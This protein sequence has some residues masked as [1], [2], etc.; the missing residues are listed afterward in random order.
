[1]S[2]RLTFPASVKRA[3]FLFAAKD[4]SIERLQ[5]ERRALEIEV[6][7]LTMDVQK[8]VLDWQQ[9]SKMEAELQGVADKL[10]ETELKYLLTKE[11]KGKVEKDLKNTTERLIM[12]QKGLSDAQ[13]T[14]KV[15]EAKIKQLSADNFDLRA[16]VKDKDESSYREEKLRM[17]NMKSLDA[18]KIKLEKMGVDDKRQRERLFSLKSACSE[19]NEAYE[20]V[21]KQNHE[22]KRDMEDVKKRLSE[23]DSVL[24]ITEKEKEQMEEQILNASR[25]IDDLRK[26]SRRDESVSPDSALGIS[27]TSAFEF[28]SGPNSPN[29][30]ASDNAFSGD[31]FGQETGLLC[32]MPT[33]IE[34]FR[35]VVRDN[36]VLRGKLFEVAVHKEKQE[37]QLKHLTQLNEILKNDVS[38]KEKSVLGLEDKVKFLEGDTRDAKN[39]VVELERNFAVVSAQADL[40]KTSLENR[41]E[42]FVDLQERIEIQEEKEK[43][44]ELYSKSVA[45]KFEYESG[46]KKKYEGLYR[47]LL[48]ESTLQKNK[49]QNIEK[50]LSAS[51]SD[52]DSIYFSAQ[53]GVPMATV[54]DKVDIVLKNKKDLEVLVSNLQ[55]ECADLQ[56][57]NGDL[58]KDL[59]HYLESEKLRQELEGELKATRIRDEQASAKVVKLDEQKK[60]LQNENKSLDAAISECKKKEEKLEIKAGAMKQTISELEKAN[61][62]F[63]AQNENL[64]DDLRRADDESSK[65]ASELKSFQAKMAE[66]EITNDAFHAE[67]EKLRTDIMALSEAKCDVELTISETERQI[68]KLKEST[69]KERMNREIL[70]VQKNEAL[71]H[72]EELQSELNGA[73]N[74]I[75]TMEEK[76][77]EAEKSIEVMEKSKFDSSS[78]NRRLAD[79]LQ[80]VKKD[81]SE[82]EGRYNNSIQE[83]ENLQQKLN[84]ASLEMAKLTTAHEGSVKRNDAME[85]NLIESK[86]K[87]EELEILLEKTRLEK[88]NV[89]RDVSQ[90]DEVIQQLEAK[91]HELEEERQSLTNDLYIATRKVLA[92][93]QNAETLM[94]E[95]NHMNREM[96]GTIKNTLNKEG[97]SNE[98]E[99]TS[100]GDSD[101]VVSEN[102]VLMQNLRQSI[103][104]TERNLDFFRSEAK[105]PEHETKSCQRDVEFIN[106]EFSLLRNQLSSFSATSH[107]LCEDI[108]KLKEDLAQKES[109]LE[110]TKEQHNNLKEENLENRESIIQLQNKCTELEALFGEYENKAEKQHADLVRTNQQIST[111]DSNLLRSEQKKTALEKELLV[112]HEKISYLEANARAM[113]DEGRSD[114]KKIATLETEYNE[115]QTLARELDN[116]EATLREL[117]GKLDDVLKEKEEAKTELY[118]MREELRQQQVELKNARK[119][120]DH[121]KKQ[122]NSEKDT[123]QKVELDLNENTAVCKTYKSN[124]QDLERSLARLREE[125]S[126]L[127]EKVGILDTTGNALRKETELQAIEMRRLEEELAD[128]KEQYSNLCRNHEGSE[129]DRKKLVNEM[130]AADER[131]TKLQGTCDELLKEK[132][133]SSSKVLSLNEALEVIIS[134]NEETAGNLKTDLLTAKKELSITK[135]ALD[136]RQKQVEELQDELKNDELKIKSLEEKKQEVFEKYWTS[137]NELTEAEGTIDNLRAENKELKQQNASSAQRAQNLQETL[138]SERETNEK[139]VSAWSD[140]MNKLKTLHQKV[141]EERGNFK[142]D[143]SYTQ[144]SLTKTEDDLKQTS[145][146]LSEKERVFNDDVTKRDQVLEDFSAQNTNLKNELAKTKESLTKTCAENEDLTERLNFTSE[147]VEWLEKELQEKNADIE[148]L[149]AEAQAKLNVVRKMKATNSGEHFAELPSSEFMAREEQDGIDGVDARPVTPLNT[150]MKDVVNS[151]HKS[152][153]SSFNDNRGL[154]QVLTDKLEEIARLE[155]GL[156]KEKNNTS[157]MKRYLHDLEKKKGKL[158]DEVKRLRRRLEALKLKS[159]EMEKEKDNEITETKGDKI[160]LE[161]ELWDTKEALEES[162]AKLKTTEEEKDRYAKDLESSRKQIVDAK[163]DIKGSQ[164]QLDALQE[165]ILQLKKRTFELEAN[166]RASQQLI[167]DKDKELFANQSKID[168]LE[169][170]YDNA[171]DKKTELFAKLSRADER[172]ASLENDCQDNTVKEATLESQIASLEVKVDDRSTRL[173]KTEEELNDSREKCE[174]L[175]IQRGSLQATNEILKQQLDATKK[176]CAQFQALLQKEKELSNTFSGQLNEVKSNKENLDRELKGTLEQKEH[177]QQL[178]NKSEE[179]LNTA[180]ENNVS[181]FH[182]IENLKRQMVKVQSGACADSARKQLEIGKLKAEGETL[183]KELKDKEREHNENTTKFKVTEKENEF[184]KKDLAHKHSRESEL[185]LDLTSTNSK[186]HSYVIEREC[187]EREVKSVLSEMEQQKNASQSKEER[188]ERLRT[189]YENEIKFLQDRVEALER[190][191]RIIQEANEQ[192]RHADEIAS[193]LAIESKDMEIDNLKLRLQATRMHTSEKSDVL[194]IMKEQLDERT[195]QIADLM[196]QLRMLKESY[197]LEL[198]SLH[199][200]LKCAQMENMLHK[201]EEL[202]G[203][204]GARQE[205]ELLEAI[206]Q[207]RKESE[208]LR[209]LLKGKMKDMKSLRKH[210]LTDR[211]SGMS[212]K[213]GYTT[214]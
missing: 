157:E 105:V 177:I 84:L 103:R 140:Q 14:I 83:E 175:E 64:K 55:A 36:E 212:R 195:R 213:P 127:E 101:T 143:L 95:I 180:E 123:R 147:K 38:G 125:N 196:E 48:E 3:R 204:F 32:K 154:Q 166:E 214:Y 65:L 20:I 18:L 99:K 129:K 155:E 52:R 207:S 66:I 194:D 50:K 12:L 13:G 24:E 75:S 152:C 120:V 170:L 40:L 107:K 115:K 68:K 208:R 174:E 156:Q 27:L 128:T 181:S 171:N 104:A 138:Q 118:G 80:L 6:A 111:L 10:K 34:N 46:E 134:S 33:M 113:K 49:L 158:E 30:V 19:A 4:D 163:F 9:K 185:K 182:E 81:L 144:A 139:E 164:Q 44:L 62:N 51:P 188:L 47:Q 74:H 117:R 58:Q 201:R 203:S 37:S 93:Q 193:K 187:W 137:Q 77:K 119:E 16:M 39:K 31:G 92:Q 5:E 45:E 191:V 130:I 110:E 169:K 106:K 136:R 199:A 15:K 73:R 165:N 1:M 43:T 82:M 168:E 197:H 183:K 28:S 153:L 142:R 98:E 126:D 173:D 124:L 112:C 100:Q 54:E 78:E 167:H 131:I 97:K 161:K 94:N 190:E 211:V 192:Q 159:V 121:L 96:K 57:A 71:N 59:S 132:E 72:C 149:L 150:S 176:D 17:E 60:S 86:G 202:S 122:M 70:A 67:N 206:K 23:K 189:R 89:L 26:S 133:T 114:K 42:D 22:M 162:K 108:K 135:S 178:L 145:E 109:L 151:F 56:L 21:K 79:E 116:T 205:T 102:E 146:V 200:D 198:G 53:G 8:Q 63:H 11:E 172:I 209:T 2:C 85:R 141:I 61:E 7:Q 179:S 25:T 90:K 87:N 76:Q 41:E 186:L 35:A 160:L 88:A 210:I 91:K 69:D 29:S 184:L 148:D